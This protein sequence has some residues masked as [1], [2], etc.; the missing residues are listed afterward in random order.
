MAR[1]TKKELEA[2]KAEI[3]LANTPESSN[4]VLIQFLMMMLNWSL[5]DRS[6]K[7]I[8]Q[9]TELRLYMDSK[10]RDRRTL[11]GG[12]PTPGVRIERKYTT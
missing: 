2:W 7:A 3:D 6:S 5:K 12:S 4:A 1:M 9:R 10:K 8:D 11:T